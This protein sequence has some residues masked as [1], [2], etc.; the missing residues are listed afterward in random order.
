M[1]IFLMKKSGCKTQS[2]SNPDI[3]NIK[4]AICIE[5]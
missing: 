5:L 2:K 3:W 4:M 1:I